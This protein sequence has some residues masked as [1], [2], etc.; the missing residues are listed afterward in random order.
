MSSI[1]SLALLRSFGLSRLFG[2]RVAAVGCAL[3]V[4]VAAGAQGD[5]PTVTVDP[6]A[7][8]GV[9]VDSPDEG[10]GEIPEPSGPIGK[11]IEGVVPETGNAAIDTATN[12]LSSSV[13]GL[14]EAFIA[15]LPQLIIG[16]L[17]VIATWLLARLATRLATHL[18]QKAHLRPNLID[19]FGIFAR[20]LVW[21]L[22]L[23]IA[24]SIVFPGFGPGQI[25][26]GAGLASIAIGL[27]FQDIFENFFAGILILLNFPFKAGDFIEVDGVTG[28]VEDIAIRMTM[29]R[30]TDGQLVLIPNSTIYKHKVT[31]LTSK[32]SRRLHLAVGIAYGED[33]AGGRALI[34]DAVK[35]CDS[36]DA[37][38]Q[39]PE[40]LA[41]G[42]GASSIDF[43]VIWWTRSAPIDARRSTDQVVE[44]IKKA[45][46]DAG[47]EIPYPY[48]T[49]TVSP[50]EPDI[51]RALKTAGRGADDHA[52]DDHA[53]DA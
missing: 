3:L 9:S 26:A 1:F 30:Q 46:D 39:D 11:A 16:L 34:L 50:N 18:G 40:V 31:V 53:D 24:A 51:I 20:I 36:V 44:A 7:V 48:R 23:M 19:L 4:A 17:V 8:E 41:A 2:L 28:K 15:M 43:D 27:A 32:K 14:T 37:S 29:L 38:D 52:D 6:A 5:G 49:L 35:G 47:V 42:F 25:L 33:L 45:L 21:F 10:G 13:G 22:G 12:K